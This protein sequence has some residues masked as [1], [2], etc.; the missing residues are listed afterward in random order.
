MLRMEYIG[1][2]LLVLVT[3]LLSVTLLPALLLL[4]LQA[5]FAGNLTFLRANLFV[6]PPWCCRVSSW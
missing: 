3:F 1:G 5:A 6:I 2:K 4:I